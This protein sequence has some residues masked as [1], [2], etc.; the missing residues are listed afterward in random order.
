MTAE[1]MA[2]CR[3][4]GGYIKAVPGESA[5]ADMLNTL[6][7]PPLT[8]SGHSSRACSIPEAGS[9]RHLYAVTTGLLWENRLSHMIQKQHG[10]SETIAGLTWGGQRVMTSACWHQEVAGSGVALGG[11]VEITRLRCRIAS[12]IINLLGK[13]KLSNNVAFTGCVDTS[14][15]LQFF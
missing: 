8:S 10:I 15:V 7:L 11:T 14:Y 12:R 13:N 5:V 9:I 2:Y 4:A 1:C 6:P 3:L